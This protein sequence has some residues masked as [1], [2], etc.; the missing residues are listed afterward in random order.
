MHQTFYAV[1]LHDFVAERTDELDAKSGDPITVVAQSNEE[2][3]VAKP[4]RRLG[5]P[6]LIPAS[7]VELRDPA[8]NL[9]LSDVSGIIARGDL[10][11]VEDWKR[12]M[13]KYKQSSIS[14]GVLD[15]NSMSPTNQSVIPSPSQ[16]VYGLRTP[17]N[18]PTRAPASVEPSSEN[19]PPTPVSMEDPNLLPPGILVSAEVVD[20]HFENDE[21]WF[22]INAL[23]LP[24][25]PSSAVML[26]ARQLVLFRVY[27]DFYDFQIALLDAF[28][29]E[30]GRENSPP[31]PRSEGGPAETEPTRI[32]PFMPGPM[33]QV[34]DVLTALRRRELDEYLKQLCAL[35]EIN[36]EHVLRHSLVRSFF[37]LKPGD[38]ETEVQNGDVDAVI[39]SYQ[40]PESPSTVPQ[41]YQ[42]QRQY[43][44]YEEV[45]DN[46]GSLSLGNN[47][48]PLVDD[49]RYEED[50]GRPRD[51][52]Y[53]PRDRNNS[54][55]GQHT[56]GRTGSSASLA[57]SHNGSSHSIPSPREGTSPHYSR[58][59]NI[60]ITPSDGGQSSSTSHRAPSNP[61]ISAT[62]PQTAFLKI[63]IFHRRTDDLIAIRVNPRVSH[64]QL[65]N[66][67]RER[68]GDEI[69]VVSYRDSMTG[70]FAD[71]LDDYALR[72]WLNHADKHVLYAS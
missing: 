24:E 30:A 29:V 19:R 62:N 40:L 34:D 4:I 17:P 54:R 50:Y 20:Y 35:R 64:N 25:D 13:H 42:D 6:G 49:P 8:T 59:S 26:P 55:N 7:F 58:T 27:D 11:K 65:M 71:L 57:L 37:S 3:F 33:P 18:A 68:L 21:F 72:E 61:S 5:R 36:A 10:P 32:L 45:R 22:R 41:R 69:E 14:L 63:K 56:H 48:S 1:V 12:A 53:R 46:V 60:P 43:N 28:P 44:D 66:K 2:W 47:R 39:Q 23:Y 16:S 31:S 52:D 70:G 67:V 38:M 9:P 15:D 51:Y